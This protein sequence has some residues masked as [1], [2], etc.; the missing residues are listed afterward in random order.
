[1]SADAQ[2]NLYFYYSDLVPGTPVHNLGAFPAAPT[3]SEV[4]VTTRHCG[5]L[6]GTGFGNG[7]CQV[8][9][10]TGNYIE[11]GAG[12]SFQGTYSIKDEAT[13]FGCRYS[14]NVD[15]EKGY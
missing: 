12:K 5:T 7:S 13:G 9:T 15:R 11:A 2:T 10:L 6:V 8:L 4:T 3:G 14:L 1:M